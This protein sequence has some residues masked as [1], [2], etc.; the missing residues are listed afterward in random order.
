MEFGYFPGLF[1]AMVIIARIAH[2]QNTV[3][4]LALPNRSTFDFGLKPNM[5]YVDNVATVSSTPDCRVAS[6]IVG[7]GLFCGPQGAFDGKYSVQVCTG[8]Q[9]NLARIRKSFEEAAV[10]WTYDTCLD[11]LLK[12]SL[13]NE[14]LEINGKYIV[15]E[16]LKARRAILPDCCL[17]VI[18]AR[19]DVA[20]NLCTPQNISRPHSPQRF[21]R[22]PPV[23]S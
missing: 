1:Y 14:C 5:L 7:A 21:L 22:N 15:F 8:S 11:M 12:S 17:A 18:T 2:G 23:V 16:N 10:Y 9:I 20:F 6:G 19:L 4:D 3:L 13:Y